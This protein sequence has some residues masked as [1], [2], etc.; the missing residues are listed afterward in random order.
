HLGRGEIV[1]ADMKAHAATPDP[2][3]GA[4]AG[5]NSVPVL[6]ILSSVGRQAANGT[7]AVAGGAS[8]PGGVARGRAARFSR[9]CR[10]T[11]NAGRQVRPGSRH[12]RCPC[13][14]GAAGGGQAHA[15]SS[16]PCTYNPSTNPGAGAR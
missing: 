13:A 4:R 6:D 7:A 14:A 11:V 5:A 3:T 10:R 15:L 12:G 8:G 9:A 16:R 1:L 2:G